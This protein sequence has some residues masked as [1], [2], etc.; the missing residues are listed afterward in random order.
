M[1]MTRFIRKNHLLRV[2]LTGCDSGAGVLSVWVFIG[3]GG[4][5]VGLAVGA[6]GA[7]LGVNSRNLEL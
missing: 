6:A 3:E 7:G 1:A 2:N 5:G 4:I